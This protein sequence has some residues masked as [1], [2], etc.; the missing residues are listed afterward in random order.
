MSARPAEPYVPCTATSA[1]PR[2]ESLDLFRGLMVIL[3]I[4]ANASTRMGLPWWMEHLY[5]NEGVR[6]RIADRFVFLTWVDIIFPGFLFIP[7]TLPSA[8][9]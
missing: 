3:M 2:V 4:F 6:E 5:M 9:C 8:H 7:F 1:P